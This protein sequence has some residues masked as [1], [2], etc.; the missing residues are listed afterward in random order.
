[1]KRIEFHSE[2]EEDL[3]EAIDFYEGRDEGLGARFAAA[4]RSCLTAIPQRAYVP[5]ARTHRHLGVK[6]TAVSKR[7]PYR[8]F[9]IDGNDAIF[10][11]AVMHNRRREDAWHHRI[12]P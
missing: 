8:V 6:C 3:N 10:V 1:M 12:T 2:A 9:F 4:V 11:L 7:W 5:P